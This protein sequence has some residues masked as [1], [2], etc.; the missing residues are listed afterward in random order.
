MLQ[1]TFLLPEVTGRHEGRF[2][3]SS[4]H[5][6]PSLVLARQGGGPLPPA[7][8]GGGN[9]GTAD[10]Q[11]L[12]DFWSRQAVPGFGGLPQAGRV[13][14][15][16]DA[17]VGQEGPKIMP[18]TPSIPPPAADP[19]QTSALPDQAQARMVDGSVKYGPAPA[20][21]PTQAAAADGSVRFAPQSQPPSQAGASP[22]WQPPQGVRMPPV[23]GFGPLPPQGGIFRPPKP[24][25]GPLAPGPMIMPPVRGG[26]G[27]G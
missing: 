22:T 24:K 5:L 12:S 9:S 8:W 25:Q 6:I 2:G 11:R 20:P 7:A 17:N 4:R 21:M 15:G 16:T 1:P 19:M 27:G 26:F 3:A 10:Q 13:T 18:P 23:P 14:T